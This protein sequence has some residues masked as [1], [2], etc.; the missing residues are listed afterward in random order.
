MPRIHILG[1]S[2]SLVWVLI[3]KPATERGAGMDFQSM[4]MQHRN[5]R[6]SPNVSAGHTAAEEPAG[7]QSPRAAHH[8]DPRI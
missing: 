3:R 5:R 7:E 2:G 4:R 8:A 6:E 1:A